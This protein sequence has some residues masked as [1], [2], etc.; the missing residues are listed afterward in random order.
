[1]PGGGRQRDG[2]RS[3]DSAD[4]AQRF[5]ALEQLVHSL[6]EG[7]KG[8]GGGKGKGGSGSAGNAHGGGGSKG[9]YHNRG[10]GEGAGD[11]GRT[12]SRPG[13]WVCGACGASPCFG[14]TSAC[15][16]CGASRGSGGGRR[17]RWDGAGAAGGGISRAASQA[18]YLGPVGAGGSRPLLGG[19][20]GQQQPA[21][22]ASKTPNQPPADT[23]P[24]HRIPGS[25][26]AARAEQRGRPQQGGRAAAGS[27]S[28]PNGTA[29]YAEMVASPNSWAALAEEDED[30]EDDAMEGCAPTG[31][32]DGP[33]PAV[34]VG[35]DGHD[36]T[37]DEDAGG[38]EDEGE[39]HGVPEQTADA[40]ALKREWISHCAACRLLERDGRGVPQPLLAEARNQRD[41]AERRW[42]AAKAPHPLH[43]RLRWAESELRDA[44][45]KE[46]ARREELS[47]H[48]RE[49]AAKTKDIEKRLE[50]DI[51]RT[52]RKREALDALHRESAAGGTQHGAE[53]AARVAAQGISSD[54][55]PA[56][57]AAIERLGTPLSE[58]QEA[59][60]RELQLVA[61]SLG[62]VEEVLRCGVEQTL[63]SS[64]PELYDIGDS[65]GG[66]RHK[67]DDRRDGDNPPTTHDGGT[68]QSPA[69]AAVPRWVK[70]PNGPWR[71][72]GSSLAAAEEA[73]RFVRQRKADADGNG[74]AGGNGSATTDGGQ[75]QAMERA[76][77]ATNDLAV[78][79]RLR[80]D[81]AH[82]QWEEA[83]GL[84]QQRKDEQQ[85]LQEDA[86]R[87]E[88]D[89]RRLEE[90][91]RH[92][93]EMQRAAALRQAEEAKQRSELIAAMSP[94]Q[95]A[96]AAEVHAQQTAIGAMAFGTP[97][98]AAAAAAAAA[99]PAQASGQGC[100]GS[101]E[102]ERLMRMSDEEYAQW[103]RD[104]QEQW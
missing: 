5:A 73:R 71:R 37:R 76:A 4:L 58:E 31:A 88:R 86:L 48:L 33:P 26:A 78:A 79:E 75:W 103:N 62:R 13:D 36:P 61:V 32:G 47:S 3:A 96:L 35:D 98:A 40:A 29:T 99:A 25:S 17:G 9:A 77:A 94:A 28:K 45:C 8:G 52:A 63:A 56:L 53:E 51:A 100:D 68:H 91:Q 43:K 19:R 30:D 39:D 34:E 59:A 41:E 80:R 24:T 87:R 14:R 12:R 23:T 82:R 15:F 57:L 18:T 42:R 83:Q 90:L 92:Q 20:G 65:D 60:R 67:D 101:D 1:M 10:I 16:R 93:E 2:G 54:V 95:L 84:Q 50:V 44:E 6:R 11:G 72:G 21:V 85:L 64:G 49:A 89:Q 55:A 7:G 70:A 38:D 66:A 22:P 46:Q 104:A 81:A 27:S 97:E 69:A 102:A 74:L